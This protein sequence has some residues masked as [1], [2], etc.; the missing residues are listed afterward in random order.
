[1][2]FIRL[3]VCYL[4]RFILSLRYRVRITGLEKLR[5]LKGKTLVLPNHPALVDPML[6]F[7]HL[8]PYLH[9]R[10]MVYEG[11]FQNPFMWFVGKLID[12]LP[13]P[14]LEKASASARSQAEAA[15]KAVKEGL[16]RGENHVMWPAGRLR[17]GNV[18][19]LGGTRALTDILK[20]VPDAHVV[21]VRTRG[22]WGSRFSRA[23]TGEGPSLGGVILSGIGWALASL[24][25]FLPRRKVSITV[26]VIDRSRLP[27]LTVES[28]NPWFEAW[29]NAEGPEQPV[30]VPYHLFLGPRT[31]E[32]PKPRG[33]GEVDLANVK[34]QTRAAVADLVARALKRPLTEQEQQPDVKLE[35]LRLDSLK[36]MEINQAVERRFGFYSDLVPETI[37]QLW[38]LAE[39]LLPRK[40]PRPA[41]PEWFRPLSDT[42]PLQLLGETIPEALV[43]RAL[44]NP[45]DAVVADDLAGVL[46][47]EKLLVGA[48]TMSKRFAALPEP[49]V[50]LL[51]PASAAGDVAFVAL[52]LAGKLPVLLNWTTGPA[53]LKHAAE[54][55]QLRTVVT[56][57]AFI[58]RADVQV[59]GTKYL[60]LEELR[61]GIGKWE[62]LK[63]LLAVRW[64]P[65]GV[66]QRVPQV[67]KHRPAVVLFTSGSEKAPKAVPLTHDNIL[68]DLRTGVPFLGWTRQDSILG[69]LPPFHS[70]GTTVTGLV[71]LTTGLRV[72]RHPDPTDAGGLVRKIAAYKTTLLVG[73]PTF[74]SY[75]LDRA[76]SG[77]LDSLR[78]IIVGAE[79]CPLALFDLC[80]EKAPNAEVLE[81]YG[82]TECSPVVSVNPPHANRPG[83]IGKPLPGVEVCVVNLQA[84]EH[85][86]EAANQPI[87]PEL[88]LGRDQGGMLLVSGPIV[89]PG[90][91]AYDGPSPFR[92]LNGKRWYVTGDLASIDA[93]GYIHFSGR[94]K[95]F[96]KIGGEMVSLPALEEPFARL[97]P[98]RDKGLPRVAVEAAEGD[99]KRRIVLFATEPIT[100]EK[101]NDILEE[102]GFHGI[103]RLDEVRRVE[104]IPVLGT[105]KTDYKVLRGQ[106]DL[107]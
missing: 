47:F 25:F 27:E 92:E 1:M 68:S 78:W 33:L 44:H 59:E 74:A 40:P 105:G 69:F 106:I 70:F 63:T 80:K 10:A 87:P 6:V 93:D 7:V 37:G 72:V 41:P 13:V 54:V 28:I 22:V 60:F 65:G 31:H 8:W 11:N 39:G 98:P 14:D 16:E 48:L 85:P 50:G 51:L 88:V 23:Y 71:P 34:P 67:D 20:S 53:N 19:V 52:H 5:P 103:M 12:A 42:G 3:L 38:A 24:L 81:G 49:N 21:V 26:D 43:N 18:E 84:F 62:L 97:Y 45:R 4:L 46:T 30:F 56:S 101:A 77:E 79:K 94:L 15:V 96:L 66:R 75:I 89:F 100:L 17:R 76:K 82:I 58:D 61:Q 32:F 73:T 104:A 95:R 91:L 9:M 107:G 57:R 29:Y 102:A 55:M 83:T 86:E 35:D 36:R 90:Y 2:N 64:A 99:G